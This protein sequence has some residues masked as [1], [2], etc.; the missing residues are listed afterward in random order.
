M[1][2]TAAI[3]GNE[4][5][6]YH[7]LKRLFDGYSGESI[8]GS[9]YGL[10]GN[11]GAFEQDVRFLEKDLNRIWTVDAAQ[12]IEAGTKTL[13]TTFDEDREQVELYAQVKEIMSQAE[14]ELIF[15]DLHSVS[16][17][18]CPFI[19]IND[20][21]RNRRLSKKIGVPI[22][23]GLEEYIR[24]SFLNR[25]N[26][27]G[28]TAIGFEGGNHRAANTVQNQ[29]AFIHLI[30]Q[31][32]GVMN[33]SHQDLQ[34]H[35]NQLSSSL[36]SSF[37]EVRFRQVIQ[38]KEVF[39]MEPGYANFDFI[40]VNEHLAR[41]NNSPVAAPFRGRI[42]MP[43]YQPKGNDGFFIVRPILG[44]ALWLSARLRK[45]PW[46]PLLRC[47]PGVR[48][49]QNRPGRLQVN[50]RIAR[51][52]VIPLFHLLGFQCRHQTQDYLV[53]DPREINPV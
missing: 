10:I 39:V 21:L 8:Q 53:F 7:A 38:P 9:V 48:R 12:E 23:L 32:T 33:L 30:L 16:S 27:L 31:Y 22:V 36:K 24:G 1:V 26:R 29:Y 5:S 43:L 17:E 19:T 11:V 2:F 37:Y 50:R 3:H 13:S 18:T 14:G 46:S 42:L 25:V 45:L 20:T 41:L 44:V 40:E 35:H 51:F 49:V 28:Y 47:L 6:G 34:H 4:P 52:L 15:V